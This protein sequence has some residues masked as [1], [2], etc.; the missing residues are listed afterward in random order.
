[1]DCAFAETFATAAAEITA[2]A[3]LPAVSIGID[4]DDPTGSDYNGWTKNVLLDGAAVG[5]V[6]GFISDH[7]Y[8]YGPGQENDATLLNNTD[9]N[10]ANIR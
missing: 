6:P 7:S 3:G 8:M 4:S 9:A 2:T 1:M 5:F 10:P